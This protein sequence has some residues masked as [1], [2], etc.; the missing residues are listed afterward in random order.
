[1]NVYWGSRYEIQK[2]HQHIVAA[3]LLVPF[4]IVLSGTQAIAATAVSNTGMTSHLKLSIMTTANDVIAPS[5]P[6]QLKSI[7]ANNSSQ[8][9]IQWNAASDNIAV[10]AYRVY[11][12]GRLLSNVRPFAD[13]HDKNSG[14]LTFSSGYSP[15][16][17]MLLR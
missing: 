2:K 1:M 12:N 6:K 5:I 8:V 15:Y 4:F 10:S 16:L 17:P 3:L 14:T 11:R 9:I 13:S 7:S